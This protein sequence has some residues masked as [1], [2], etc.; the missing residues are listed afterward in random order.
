[1][2]LFNVLD[3]A[4]TCFILIK[5]SHKYPKLTYDLPICW[6]TGLLSCCSQVQ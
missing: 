3:I 4:D 6:E 1:M 5:M 2:N